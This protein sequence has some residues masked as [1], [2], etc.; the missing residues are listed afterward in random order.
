MKS[1]YLFF[2]L[3]MLF[4]TIGSNPALSKE[5]QPTDK[6]LIAIKEIIIDFLLLKTD[7][8][9]PLSAQESKVRFSQLPSATA[10]QMNLAYPFSVL[11]QMKSSCR[12][13][14]V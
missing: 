14:M 2:S 12:L 9:S 13:P 11:L 6:Q 8:L 4:L 3:L 7:T 10:K 5:S 1:I